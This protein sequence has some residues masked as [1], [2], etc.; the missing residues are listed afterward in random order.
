MELTLLRTPIAA[1]QYSHRKRNPTD[2]NTAKSFRF[3]KTAD[4]SKD[5]YSVCGLDDYNI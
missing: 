1:L 2:N 5:V 4:S 3:K